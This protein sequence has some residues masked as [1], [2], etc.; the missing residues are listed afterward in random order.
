MK[1]VSRGHVVNHECCCA[2]GIVCSSLQAPSMPPP[3]TP[4]HPYVVVPSTAHGYPAVGHASAGSFSGFGTS[5]GLPAP[6]PTGFSTAPPAE[7]AAAPSA[8]PAPYAPPVVLPQQQ[9]QQQNL[10]LFTAPG[11]ASMDATTYPSISN[12]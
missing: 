7:S 2:A 1:L 6:T 11:V 9:Q 8:P 10:G 3:P 12:K 5:S 4:G